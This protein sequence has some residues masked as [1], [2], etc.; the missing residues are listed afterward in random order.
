[1]VE[2][3]RCGAAGESCGVAGEEELEVRGRMF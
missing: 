2:W 3:N 1:M